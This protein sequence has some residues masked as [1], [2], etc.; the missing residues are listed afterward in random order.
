[1]VFGRSWKGFAVVAAAACLGAGASGA[2]EGT[3]VA[4]GDLEDARSNHCSVRLQDGR[5]LLAGGWR[6]DLVEAQALAEVYD[7]DTGTFSA[8][9][10]MAEKRTYATASLLSDG[11]VLVA[12]GARGGFSPAEF[13]ST[14]VWDSSTGTFSSGPTMNGARF[15]HAA[16]DLADGR[17]L[18]AG[19]FAANSALKSAE[20]LESGSWTSVGDM[21]ARRHNHAAVRL[22]D[23]RVLVAGGNAGPEGGF[24]TL[25][26]CEVFDPSTDTFSAA[27]S[28][29]GPRSGAG[30]V[31]LGDGDVL[32][33]GGHSGIG[34]LA[35]A[36]LYDAGSNSWSSA[37]TRSGTG[38]CTA[39]LLDD[40][41]V[42]VAGGV[43]A[44]GDASTAADLYDPST[45][46]FTALD[47]MITGRSNHTANLLED[48]S[49]L[50][51]GGTVLVA[52]SLANSHDAAELY[53]PGSSGDTAPPTIS[54]A[55]ADPA[56]LWPPDHKMRS[57]TVTATVEDDQDPNPTLSILSVS[58]NEP[59]EGTGDGDTPGDWTITGAL[60]V[61]LRSE[62]SGSGNGRV[63][64]ITLV[65]TDASGNE[66]FE[67][68]DVV[69]PKSRR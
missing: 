32:V 7:P 63:Y 58:S 29:P 3:F 44:G 21:A 13:A 8:T 46:T 26:S 16:V 20:V 25:S 52:P 49:V 1:M 18:V 65:A 60:T 64:T 22:D 38:P 56:S 24:A 33:V 35:T 43:V 61:D 30:A 6:T 23:G 51:A 27:A 9:G 34:P 57:V 14:E 62:R 19:G 39:T 45:G 28:M 15:F 69:V 66:S 5:V 50:L 17:V 54:G 67:T 12:G 42:L 11:S 10:S 48:G 59:E 47:P 41:R 55:S 53:V 68:V 2:G 37:G 4:T 40:G 31:L 36:L